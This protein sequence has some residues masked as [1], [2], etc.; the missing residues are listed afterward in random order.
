MKPFS[1]AAMALLLCAAAPCQ[2]KRVV[3]D[4]NRTSQTWT[5][6]DFDA[7]LPADW[8]GFD[9]LAVELRL[10]SPQRFELRVRT[11]GGV[12]AV[13]LSP[14]PNVWI[15]SAIPL[16]FLSKPAQQGTDLASVHNKPRPM[17]FLNLMGSPGPLDAVTGIEV[18]IPSPIGA[19][20]LELRNFRLTKEDPGDALLEP[21][22]LV[23]EFGQWA[24]DTWP[25][26]ARSLD[27]LKASWAAEEKALDAGGAKVCKYG[28]FEGTK[29]KATGFFRVEKIDGRWWFIDPDGHYFW[30]AGADVMTSSAVTSAQG[31]EALFTTIPPAVAGG[32]GGVSFYTANLARRFGADWVQ[33][34]IDLTL[35]RLTAW[36]FNTIGNW[37]D[38][39]LGG[40]RRVPYTVSLGVRA[41]SGPM[42]VTDVYDP[43]FAENAE[44]A[45]AQQAAVRKDDPYLL[46]YFLGNEL[47]WPGKESVAVDA[48]LAGPP[49]PLQRELK[50][51][52]AAGDKPERRK[53]FLYE[54]YRKFVDTVT[55]AVR[56][57]DPNHV[58]LGLRFGGSAP[59]EVI[60]AS[61][62]FDVYSLNNY[63]YAVD[64]QEIEKIRGLIDRPILIGEFHFGTPGRGMTPGL[65]QAANQQERGAAYRYYVENAA[66][67]PSLVGTHWFQWLDEP[68]T[69]R[70]DGEN[71][72]IGVI[73]V[74]DRPYGELVTAMKATHARLLEVHAGK[75]AP[76]ATRAKTQ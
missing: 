21:K 63:N 1:L 74:T 37:S 25:G 61:K 71:Y 15:R 14:V 67:D 8:S 69:G 75:T 47:P 16:A 38:A 32:R 27:D 51:F 10:S 11:A 73:D 20:A 12:R 76:V 42:G 22:P 28:G 72:N 33:P 66:A 4:A 9:F 57:H 39:R 44:R 23:D 70:F 30:S 54:T 35:R 53:S 19:P 49:S 18:A 2:D 7:K 34:W 26:K 31:R 56:K 24:P 45:I 3:F 13:R 59:A 29:A 6:E 46:G 17:M 5:L 68:S 48:I 62:A 50:S 40:A 55:A 36:G 64:R 52:L 41:N 60:R 65:R 58:I 43:A